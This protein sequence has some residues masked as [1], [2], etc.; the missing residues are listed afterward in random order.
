MYTFSNKNALVWTPTNHPS[1]DVRIAR[2]RQNRAAQDWAIGR[3]ILDRASKSITWGAL[4]Y[5]G[6]TVWPET[7]RTNQ[8]KVERVGTKTPTELIVGIDVRD[9]VRD[10]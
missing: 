6:P 7:T 9:R 10:C 1:E 5:T 3:K 2:R 8:G 4:H